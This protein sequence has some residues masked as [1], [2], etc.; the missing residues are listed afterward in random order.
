MAN[1]S[2]RWDKPALTQVRRGAGEQVFMGYSVRD[3]HWRYTEWDEGRKGVE[4]YDEDHDP[5]ELH[6]LAGDPKNAKMIERMK[7]LLRAA[8][9]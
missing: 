1:P 4:L 7:G 8:K 6:N 5:Q 3:E 9:R 2:A